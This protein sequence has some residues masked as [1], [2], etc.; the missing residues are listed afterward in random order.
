[1]TSLCNYEQSHIFGLKL[2]SFLQTDLDV[3][4]LLESQ[5]TYSRLLLSLQKANRP[6]K[7]KYD[8]YDET[9]NINQEED[10]NESLDSD[11]SAE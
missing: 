3:L 8:F 2:L 10:H 4:L 11:E 5:Y 6:L 7:A 9:G 1:M